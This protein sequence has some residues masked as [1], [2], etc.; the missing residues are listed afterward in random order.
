[1]QLSV[2][3]DSFEAAAIC[4]L[5][6]ASVVHSEFVVLYDCAGFSMLSHFSVGILT[7]MFKILQNYYPE[8]LARAFI[9][10]DRPYCFSVAFNL[11]VPFIQ[12]FTA[13]KIHIL[14]SEDANEVLAK[15]VG[16]SGLPEWLGGS[17][18]TFHLPV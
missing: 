5:E 16:V 6:R 11:V 3:K 17:S 15:N 8:C 14:S 9:L 10:P 4:F 12:P 2:E 7:S 13:S 1:M 18:S